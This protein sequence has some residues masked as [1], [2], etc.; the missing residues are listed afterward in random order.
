MRPSPGVAAPPL[1][2]LA[3]NWKSSPKNNRKD[4]RPIRG[5]ENFGASC[6]AYCKTLSLSMLPSLFLFQFSY[7][8]LQGAGSQ[9]LQALE[10]RD[11]VEHVLPRRPQIVALGDAD[12]HEHADAFDVLLPHP[13][14]F[15]EFSESKEEHAA[16][17]CPSAL[18][19]LLF[20]SGQV[21]E[22]GQR[23]D[24]GIWNR[25]AE[26]E[27]IRR[28]RANAHARPAQH[29]RPSG[30]ARPSA[31]S[32][33]YGPREPRSTSMCMPDGEVRPSPLDS[34]M[35]HMSTHMQPGGVLLCEC[36]AES[37]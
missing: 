20:K 9:Q 6:K 36:T 1:S 7:S 22:L 25:G 27:C 30:L 16:C 5:R 23:G 3:K 33:T 11:A 31:T 24:D 21:G 35:I 19:E 2:R 12:G 37:P 8:R 34:A 29:A 13:H 17:C 26:D 28:R 4:Q 18:S 32:V 14:S 15:P 10:L